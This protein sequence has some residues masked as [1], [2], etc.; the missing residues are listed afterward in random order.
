MRIDLTKQ[1]NKKTPET[2]NSMTKF[3]FSLTLLKNGTD[4]HKKSIFQHVQMWDTFP[5]CRKIGKIDLN[6]KRLKLQMTMK[7]IN[8]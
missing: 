4:T 1:T 5:D 6:G 3:K 8:L 7:R 2:Q